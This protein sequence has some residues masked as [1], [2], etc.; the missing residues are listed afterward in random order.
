V[1]QEAKDQILVANAAIG[2]GQRLSADTI[3]WQDWPQGAVRPEYITKTAV[4]DALTSMKDSVAR[5]EFFPGEPIIA[6][7]LV[8]SDQGYMSAVLAEGMRGVSVQV[9]AE[10]AAGGYIMPNDRVDVVSTD[11]GTTQTILSD[12]K[13]LAINLRLGEAGTTGAPDTPDDPKSNIFQSTAIATLELTP[14]QGE[15]I[16]NA[17]KAGSLSLVLRSIADFASGPT[18]AQPDGTRAIRVIRYGAD[19]SV[20]TVTASSDSSVPA[21]DAGSL[22]PKTTVT[23]GPSA[24]GVID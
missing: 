6:Q 18:V 5:F 3:S 12:V 11:N 10:S 14:G 2:V 24:M 1:V 21:T 16:I 15:T 4:P 19:Q 8:K 23:T 22:V 7:K 9:S 20:T 13:V 17:A